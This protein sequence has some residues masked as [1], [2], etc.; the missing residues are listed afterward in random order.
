MIHHNNVM[1]FKDEMGAFTLAEVLITLGI[2]GIVAAMTMPVLIAGYQKNVLKNQFKKTY[3]MLSQAIVKTQADLG[4]V[5]DC[6]YYETGASV[7]HHCAEYNSNG[8]C[9]RYETNDGGSVPADVNG[10]LGECS[11]FTTAFLKNLKI[12]KTCK[13]VYDDGCI[14]AYKGYEDILRETDDS[15]TDVDI[16]K[17]GYVYLQKANLY[18]K[19]GYVFSDGSV[20]IDLNNMN[21]FAIDINGKKGPN[22]AGRDLFFVTYY[23][24][25]S[26]DEDGIPPECRTSGTGCGSGKTNPKDVRAAVGA[27]C[28]S[29]SDAKGCFGLLLNNNWE[30]DY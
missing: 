6:Y 8:T 28:S 11:V 20:L 23:S 3:S 2:I 13:K 27:N 7:P 12:I 1:I 29:R 17:K 5:P 10:P 9:K 24:D 25:G 15:L 21:I 30:M 4:Y 26:I 19:P 22:I 18:A 14:P 16:N